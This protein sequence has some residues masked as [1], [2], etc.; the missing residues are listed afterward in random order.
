MESIE[1]GYWEHRYLS[2]GTSGLGSVGENKAWKW[3]LIDQLIPQLDHVIDVGCGDLTFWEGRDCYD[4]VG[5]DIS[6]TIVKKNQLRR[7][8]WKFICS[9]AGNRIDGLRKDV[10][11][12]LDVLFHIMNENM[13]L[14]ILKNLCYYSKKYILINTWKNNPF[15]KHNQIKKIP[16]LLKNL[17]FINV[18]YSF[19]NLFGHHRITDGKYQRYHSLESYMHVFR[20]N[21]FELIRIEENPDKI[22]ALYI[23]K[24]SL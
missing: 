23:F 11:F 10:V 24:K 1:G 7:P 9:N 5:I 14:N 22:G 20:E 6:E 3:R 2:G 18:L 8:K 16:V 12:C 19:K 21:G 17:R 4:Y 13:L 15:N